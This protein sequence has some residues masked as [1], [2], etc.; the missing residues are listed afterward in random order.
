MLPVFRSPD[1]II[2]GYFIQGTISLLTSRAPTGSLICSSLCPPR[3]LC[4]CIHGSFWSAAL[5]PLFCSF[6]S[7]PSLSSPRNYFRLLAQQVLSHLW[8]YS[9]AWS[10]GWE[11]KASEG[12]Q[13]G[14]VHVEMGVREGA[15][16]QAWPL[17]YSSQALYHWLLPRSNTQASRD[18]A[19]ILL[20]PCLDSCPLSS[21]WADAQSRVSF[22]I[23]KVLEKT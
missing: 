13:M 10:L 19:R 7:R 2:Q 17:A 21:T 6:R 15:G 11:G 8:I 3:P 1:K 5:T 23:Y 18:G 22:P 4:L 16:Y 14:S 12:Q 20:P 9:A